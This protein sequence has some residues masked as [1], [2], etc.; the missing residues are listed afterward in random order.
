MRDG[1]SAGFAFI[2]FS[3]EQAAKSAIEGMHNTEYVHLYDS[4][5]AM[6]L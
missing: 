2:D 5:L 1:R 3:D 6:M 4:P